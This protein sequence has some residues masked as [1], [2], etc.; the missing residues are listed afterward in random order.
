MADNGLYIQPTIAEEPDYAPPS[1]YKQSLFDS[2]VNSFKHGLND[3]FI[4]GLATKATATYK[5]HFEDSPTLS[6]SKIGELEDKY[7]GLK[8]DEG[9][10]QA[11]ANAFIKHYNAKRYREIMSKANQSSNLTGKVVNTVASIAGSSIGE[12]PFIAGSLLTSGIATEGLIGGAVSEATEGASL[13]EKSKIGNAILRQSKKGRL[14]MGATVGAGFGAG[15]VTGNA[16]AN[17]PL[18]GMGATKHIF[19]NSLAGAGIEAGFIAGGYTL[20]KGLTLAG[21]PLNMMLDGLNS[22]FEKLTAKT[23]NNKSSSVVGTYQHPVDDIDAPFAKGLKG[24][25]VFS[26][27]YVNKMQRTMLKQMREG[28]N[29]DITPLF[30][31]GL[32][33]ASTKIK[34]YLR[35]NNINTDDA[36]AQ[37]KESIE[38]LKKDFQDGKLTKTRYQSKLATIN[39]YKNA[40]KDKFRDVTQSDAQRFVD[41]MYSSDGD[42][43]QDYG[44]LKTDD[45]KKIN[46]LRAEIMD[47][48]KIK[49]WHKF[50]QRNDIK[51]EVAKIFK[52]KLAKLSNYNAKKDELNFKHD[53]IRSELEEVMQHIAVRAHE[54]LFEREYKR[55]KQHKKALD[56]SH[57]TFAKRLAKG[58]NISADT[59]RPILTQAEKIFAAGGDYKGY[60]DRQKAQLM[61]ESYGEELAQF[62]EINNLFELAKQFYK[63][64]YKKL[65]N[66][67]RHYFNAIV[68][69]IEK[70]VPDSRLSAEALMR[71]NQERMQ[72]A[73]VSNLSKEGLFK[74]SKDYRNDLDIIKAMSGEDRSNAKANKVADIFNAV[75]KHAL[76]LMQDA[77]LP[78]SELQD[79]I[80]KNAH[81]HNRML[82]IPKDV[83]DNL[84]HKEM[85]FADRYNLA[86]ERWK[87]FITDKLDWERMLADKRVHVRNEEELS[88]LKSDY[89]DA[90][91]DNIIDKDKSSKGIRQGIKTRIKKSRKMHFK[92]AKSIHDYMREY[93]AGTVMDTV[94]ED[95]LSSSK[96]SALKSALG[97]NPVNTL[98]VLNDLFKQDEDLVTEAQEGKALKEGEDLIEQ[99][100]GSL[101]SN[102]GKSQEIN[103]AVR[104]TISMLKL[105]MVAI[106]SVFGDMPLG[107]VEGSRAF[108]NQGGIVAKYSRSIGTMLEEY[109]G[110]VGDRELEHKRE[111]LNVAS[112][113]VLG[114]ATRYATAGDLTPEVFSDLMR[115]F[116][117]LTG[118]AFHDRAMKTATAAQWARSLALNKDIAFDLLSKNQQD[119]MSSYGVDADVWDLIRKH[120]FTDSKGREYI[121]VDSINDVP[122]SDIE[123]YLKNKAETPTPYKIR[124]VRN[125]IEN[126]MS[127]FFM[128]RQDH[129]ILHPDAKVKNF[130]TW[131]KPGLSHK[132]TAL[133]EAGKYTGQFKTFAASMYNKVFAPL[134]YGKGANSLKEALFEGKAD[135]ERLLIFGLSTIPLNYA[136]SAAA[137]I[138]N[139]RTPR[140]I[141]DPSSIADSIRY[142]LGVVGSSL[143]INAT[144]YGSYNTGTEL[145]SSLAE[146]VAFDVGAKMISPVFDQ[147][148]AKSIM[149]AAK[150]LQPNAPIIKQITDFA[151]FNIL[152]SWAEP[153]WKDKEANYLMQHDQHKIF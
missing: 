29:L 82:R 93:G 122:T 27:K 78:V 31:R 37:L 103:A 85:T 12:A 101:F 126:K 127:V 67:I 117:R 33:N 128:D 38:G 131:G 146:P 35:D 113:N 145:F 106:R 141:T 49:S 71:S 120:P 108:D 54:A 79:R 105:G 61:S 140:P 130:F 123:Q 104:S 42:R 151:I 41:N 44:T 17:T 102:A 89:L 90:A 4:G 2:S 136:G 58:K 52:N 133:Y 81:N 114:T 147:F 15:D 142:S 30:K 124:K 134:F 5:Q 21:K 11:S 60:I 64:D 86:K 50:V 26:D 153:D 83:F 25:R 18:S 110:R 139:N 45:P 16:L 39:L 66:P 148:S 95:I 13:L 135:W 118:L 59:V 7:P 149:T 94:M 73:L 14:A 70:A 10:T 34:R 57:T 91:F 6:Q 51:P 22:Q 9:T 32:Y 1:Y 77:G 55:S 88:Q 137:D 99:I 48:D 97:D 92:D 68:N 20:N 125:D 119:I 84:N 150:E 96:N 143:M 3:S 28:K 116:F 112:D 19:E 36:L 109:R 23:M 115:H 80:I 152:K 53:G 24:F 65:K 87:A 63:Y 138:L 43:L 76:N 107:I 111:L 100:D 72:S 46:E 121:T 62:H 144:K 47:E 98:K 129:V 56:V 74:Y 69:G 132:D 75:Q 40:L 8:L